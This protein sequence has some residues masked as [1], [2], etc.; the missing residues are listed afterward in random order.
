MMS[1]SPPIMT[2]RAQNFPP[3]T[4]TTI[5][6]EHV[7]VG[8]CQYGVGVGCAVGVSVMSVNVVPNEKKC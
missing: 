7:V 6:L 8:K 1:V 4:T 5:K 2:N 3:M